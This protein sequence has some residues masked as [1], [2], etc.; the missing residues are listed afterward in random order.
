MHFCAFT[1]ESIEKRMGHYLR[2]FKRAVSTAFK[3]A[4]QV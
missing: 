4:E 1:K 2:A 3:R